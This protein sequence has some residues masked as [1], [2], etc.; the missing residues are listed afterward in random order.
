MVDDVQMPLSMIRW[1]SV[2]SPGGSRFA[3]LSTFRLIPGQRFLQNIV[4]TIR[5]VV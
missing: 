4:I 2:R 5:Y 3:N 1:R